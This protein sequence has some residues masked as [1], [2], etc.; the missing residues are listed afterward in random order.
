MKD[1]KDLREMSICGERNGCDESWPRHLIF[2]YINKQTSRT[3]SKC[4]NRLLSDK[5]VQS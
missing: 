1:L 5:N 3:K 2:M 4:V